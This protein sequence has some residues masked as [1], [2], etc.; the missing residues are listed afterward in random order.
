MRGLKPSATLAINER[1]AAMG[2]AGQRVYRLGLGQSPFPVPEV[3]V[4][5][6]QDNAA[7][8]DYLPV[9]GLP[10]LREEVANYHRRRNG[11][12][13]SA[14]N[15]VIGPG[16][17]QMLFILQLVHD[18][19]LLLPSPSWVSY[20]PQARLTGRPVAWVA[21]SRADRWRL[22][23]NRLADY[24][25]GAPACSRV[26]ILNYPDN[27]TGESY[28][29]AELAALA[30][31]ARRH[32]LIVVAD[33]IYGELSFADQHVSIA[34]YYPEGTIVSAGLSKWC[35][36][37]GWRLGTFLFPRE[38]RW[39][40][41]A[42]LAV[43]S[44]SH[45]AVSAPIQYA[46]IRAFQGGAEIDRYLH[47]SRRIMQ[48]LLAAWAAGLRAAGLHIVAPKGG[49]YL[50]A[51]CSAL[52]ENLSAEGLV[53][54]VTVC[55]HILEQTGVALLPGSAFGCAPEDLTLRAA[56]VD[57][58]GATALAEASSYPAAD[59]LDDA[60]LQKCCPLMMEALACL[61]SW[62]AVYR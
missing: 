47:D 52:R 44:E 37:G 39:L 13:C 40:Q 14:E 35:G 30:E 46:A 15:V 10:A 18:G 31:V 26:L 42:L 58:D 43:A 7:R 5:A 61:Q 55:E 33:E 1:C 45:S 48:A 11:L 57:F 23:A 59:A 19:E 36:A 62:C 51:D 41:D 60:F 56:C 21:T 2:A 34:K 38:L 54:D 25:S 32:E 22:T 8:K 9:S 20:A 3:V 49:F 27:P 28:D 12:N 16:S 17:K 53:D 24:L 50:L 4:R 29:E 6:L